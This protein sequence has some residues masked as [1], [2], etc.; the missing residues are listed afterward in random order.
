MVIG[1]YSQAIVTESY[2]FTSSQIPIDS[3][4]GNLTN[5]DIIEQTEQVIKNLLAVPVAAE[6]SLNKVTKT[7]C[8]LKDIGDFAIFNSVYSKH[9][10]S[11]PARSC[12][13]TLVFV[14]CQKSN[15]I[16]SLL[17]YLLSIHCDYY[18][19]FSGIIIDTDGKVMGQMHKKESNN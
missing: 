6:S 12:V 5:G 4:T 9:F 11:K 14:P 17:G 13:F 7:S 3:T 16:I 1:L 15:H 18:T 19:T 2:I 8:F 10:I